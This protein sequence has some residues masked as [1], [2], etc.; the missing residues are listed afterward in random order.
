MQYTVLNN[1]GPSRVMYRFL[2]TYADLTA[3]ASTQQI[4]LLPLPKGTLITGVRIKETTVFAGGSMSGL[5]VSVD[6][7]AS[8]VGLFA[9]AYSLFNVVADTTMALVTGWK[10]GTYAADTLACTFSATGGTGYVNQAT[11]GACFIDVELW[12]EPD[13][14]ATAPFG[15]GGTAGAPTVGGAL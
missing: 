13:L 14:T 3:A 5:T 11:S 6:S 10:A 1:L 15:V 4:T 2:L 7:V 12:L 9:T 8:G